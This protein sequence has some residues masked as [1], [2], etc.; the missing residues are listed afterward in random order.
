MVDTGDTLQDNITLKNYWIF[1][2]S[3]IKDDGKLYPQMFLK[4]A[5]VAQ[6][7]LSIGTF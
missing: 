7:I 3:V 1:I 4:E 2:K 5:L 6:A